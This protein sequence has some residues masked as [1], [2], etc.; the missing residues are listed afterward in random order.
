MFLSHK[1]KNIKLVKSCSK[2]RWLC[3][4]L[5]TQSTASC[6]GQSSLGVLASSMLF[7]MGSGQVG[8]TWQMGGCPPATWVLNCKQIW[9]FV[10]EW[11]NWKSVCLCAEL[12][13]QDDEMSL[14]V[15]PGY[16]QGTRNWWFL[17]VSLW[18]G[19]GRGV[20]AIKKIAALDEE[21]S[22]SYSYLPTNATTIGTDDDD[23][24][25]SVAPSSSSMDSS[26]MSSISCSAMGAEKWPA[27][28]PP[29]SR[30]IWPHLLHPPAPTYV[31]GYRELGTD[32]AHSSS[33]SRSHSASIPHCR[34]NQFSCK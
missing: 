25:F 11:E 1:H 33:S 12:V 14:S 24:C 7:C 4:R 34:S 29:Y 26:S 32:H 6:V 28:H 21:E 27:R 20:R 19:T 2:T 31:M 15:N 30:L 18:L 9:W 22:G 5:S 13:W 23:H 17:N 3:A 16:Q 8:S 10:C